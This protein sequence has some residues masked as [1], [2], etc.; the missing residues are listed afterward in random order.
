MF[1]IEPGVTE[2]V[3]QS[4]PPRGGEPAANQLQMVQSGFN[5]RPRAE[6]NLHRN[7]LPELVGVFQSTPPRGGEHRPAGGARIAGAF[8]STPPRGGE[9]Y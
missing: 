2:D 8:Q 3:F 9:L 4:T 1:Y 5:P 6:A 7:A